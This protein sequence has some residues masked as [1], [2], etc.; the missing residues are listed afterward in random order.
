MRRNSRRGGALLL[1][2]IVTLVILGI[3]GAFL[4]FS[5]INSRKTANDMFGLQAL[6]IAES[7]AA[8]YIHQIN[9][10][11]ATGSPPTPGSLANGQ[12][13]PMSGGDFVYPAAGFVDYGNNGVD[14]DNLNGADDD[15]ERNFLRFQVDGT[16]SGVTRRLEIL[17]SR[18]AGGVF[19][20][21]VF[22]GNSS[23]SAYSLLFNG[24]SSGGD[25]IKG[26]VYSGGDVWA[27]GNAQLLN[28]S[29]QT[30]GSTVMYA[31]SNLGGPSGP[32]YKQG[33][34]S[35]LDIRRNGSGQTTWEELAI[36]HRLANTAGVGRSDLTGVS[37]FD[38]AW[39]LANMGSTANGANNG[40][41]QSDQSSGSNQGLGRAAAQINH[42]NEPSHIFRKDPTQP[43]RDSDRTVNYAYVD[44]AKPDYYIED[45]THSGLNDIS[46]L[47]Y[48]V[49]GDTRASG[50]YLSP[51]GNNAV[52]F[53]DGNL[54]VS[55]DWLK[56]YQWVK[57][58][59]VGDMKI[60]IVVKGNVNFTDNLVYPT[61]QSDTDALAILAVKDDAR[62][63]ATA[64]NF[65]NG[66]STLPGTTLTVDQFVTQFNARAAQA[67]NDTVGQRKIPDLNI[68]TPAG[69]ERA[70]SEFNRA[71]GSGNVFYGDPG[72]GTV[73]YFESFM[74]AENN[75]YATNLDSTQASGGTQ[76][77]E[78]FGNMTAGNHVSIMRDTSKAG[79]IPLMVGF[80]DRI[81]QPS[82]VKPP[83]LPSTPGFGSGDWL[84]ASWKQIP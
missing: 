29:G 74:Y 16:Y 63:N 41:A 70:A 43:N 7:G 36:Q 13:V 65:A 1:C 62:F 38:V 26:D 44:T 61:Y 8:L 37:Y 22:A 80:D 68:N 32:T 50:V 12:T 27:Q 79:Y 42:R 9:A 19:W 67:G 57:P 55:H 5:S 76:R 54:W 24:G 59:G 23:G 11:P 39:D 73:E 31:G 14:D 4:S 35:D 40:G 2:I 60:T 33:T 52:Y 46:N 72:S 84:I 15:Y 56:T 58:P 45:P 18:S 83:A 82:G 51:N 10:K 77:V 66:S 75:F 21:A 6:Y 47:G 64:A 30:S 81:K 69:M 49:N 28:E 71:Y 17:L 53:V 48:G 34:Q 20:N 25:V 3:S 78:I